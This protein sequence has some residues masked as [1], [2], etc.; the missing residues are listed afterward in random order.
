MRLQ[1]KVD[2]AETRRL[3]GRDMDIYGLLPKAFK[4]FRDDRPRWQ[5]FLYLLATV[6][7]FPAVMIY[8]MQVYLYDAGFV[9]LA[10]FLRRV[11]HLLFGVTI[12]PNV[13]SKGALFLGH[14]HVVMDAII[15]LGDW[16]LISPFVAIGISGSEGGEFD[17]IGPTI[18]D[19]VNIGTGAKIL[20][21]VHIG[22]Y[23]KIGAN[24]VVVHDVP[25]HHTAVGA[26]ARSFPTVTREERAARAEKPEP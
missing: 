8:R 17:L 1:P 4:Q 25:A 16:V 24:S 22:D 11:N 12:G 14:G 7:S 26:P 19:H 20:G 3:V 13:R 15:T 5:L 10:T 6:D 23:T 18:G 2:W 9:P 21:P